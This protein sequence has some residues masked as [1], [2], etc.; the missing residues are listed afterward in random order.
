MR[1]RSCDWAKR[2]TWK[3]RDGYKKWGLLL[4]KPHFLVISSDVG[5]GNK[6]AFV[7]RY[8]FLIKIYVY[9]WCSSYPKAGENLPI[10]DRHFLC[11]LSSYGGFVPPCWNVNASTA[12]GWRA[13]GKAKPFFFVLILKPTTY[14]GK[15]WSYF[16][17]GSCWSDFHFSLIFSVY[18]WWDR[19]VKHSNVGMF[20]S[21]YF[22][23]VR[24]NLCL[25]R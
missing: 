18:L 24:W 2:G 22:L 3:R 4:S 11:L 8:L 21:L 7:K 25:A 13:T 12:L 19:L 1:K 9:L 17:A 16:C 15:S 20:W 10:H 6:W 23:P 5:L 14:E